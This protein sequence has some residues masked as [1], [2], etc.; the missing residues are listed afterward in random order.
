MNVNMLLYW[1]Y[2]VRLNAP[3]RCAWQ[4]RK[5]NKTKNSAYAGPNKPKSLESRRYSIFLLH[6]D[7][8][9]VYM[10]ASTQCYLLPQS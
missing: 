3:Q 1:M 6:A 8:S 9:S 7:A 2:V 5:Q 4:N 10:H